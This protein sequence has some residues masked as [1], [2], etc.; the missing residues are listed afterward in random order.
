MIRLAKSEE[1]KRAGV[2]IRTIRK[3]DVAQAAELLARLK[4][5]NG[6]FDPLLKTVAAI[7][8]A[9][10]SSIDQEM[11]SDNSVIL[12]AIEK[13]KVVGLVKSDSN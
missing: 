5:L 12:V 10:K 8:A 7:E 4:K 9:A 1:K 13:S 11:S 2:V 3:E 6:E